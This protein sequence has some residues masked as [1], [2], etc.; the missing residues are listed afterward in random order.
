MS[1]CLLANAKEKIKK[2]KRIVVKVGTSTITYPN[3]K[4]NFKLMNKLSW[5]LAD[6]MSQEREVVL[7]TSGAVGVG[8]SKLNFSTRPTLIK[9]KQAAA[10]V[11]QAALINTYQNF[12]GEYGKIAAQILLTKDDFKEGERKT[13][14]KNIFETLFGFGVLPIVNA[15][16]SISTYEIEF[17]DNDTLASEIAALLNADLLVL[18][19]DIDALYNKNP[20]TDSTAERIPYLKDFDESVADVSGGKGSTFSIG[21]METKLSAAQKC[22]KAGVIMVI[23]DGS[24]PLNIINIIE[25]KNIGTIFDAKD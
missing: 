20:R 1:E 24:D 9:E 3:G 11:G 6:L 8:A 13:N 25:G 21:G 15:N 4:T 2:S 12:L 5:V 16:D 10:S 19:T 23:A 14:T 22:T 18:L 7:V 17:S